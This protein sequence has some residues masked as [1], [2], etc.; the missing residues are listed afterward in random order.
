MQP[1]HSTRWL[2]A[3]IDGCA[4]QFCEADIP[5]HLVDR[6]FCDVASWLYAT[7]GLVLMGAPS[8]AAG[9]WERAIFY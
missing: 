8:G 1:L 2:L 4:D 5:A 3:Y 7:A 9:C 6:P